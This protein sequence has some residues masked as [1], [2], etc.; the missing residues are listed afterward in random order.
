MDSEVIVKDSTTIESK[1]NLKNNNTVSSDVNSTTNTNNS[2]STD[3]SV[4]NLNNN[5]TN[6]TN[7]GVNNNPSLNNQNSS[8]TDNSAGVNSSYGQSPLSNG[9]AGPSHDDKRSGLNSPTNTG[10]NS[11]PSSSFNGPNSGSGLSDGLNKNSS[12][13]GNPSLNQKNS[14]NKTDNLDGGKSNGNPGLGAGK[15]GTGSPSNAGKTGG[16]PAI[17]G[18]PGGGFGPGGVPLSGDPRDAAKMAGRA[19]AKAALASATG[20]ATEIPVVNKL[21]DAGVGKAVDKAVDRVA[22]M[23]ENIPGSPLNKE[24]KSSPEP[25]QDTIEKLTGLNPQQQ[26]ILLVGFILFFVFVF[27][28]F[29][30]IVNLLVE[31]K[32]GILD[33]A[34]DVINNDEANQVLN[35]LNES[36]DSLNE[37]DLDA[38]YISDDIIE[39]KLVA[40]QY[41]LNDLKDMF[42]SN[43][44]CDK[45]NN[46]ANDV[47]RR[48]YLKL[49]DLYY[50][51]K[52]KYNVNLDLSL[53]ISTL[54]YNS[55]DYEN[56]FYL[57]LSD[58][59]R[60]SIV[61]QDWKPSETT[62]L[63]W[64]YDYESKPNYLVENDSSMDMQILAKNMVAKVTTEKC[65]NGDNQVVTTQDVKDYEP[66]LICDEG[67][68]LEK[69]SSKYI[70]DLD[71]Y[72]K[73]L[74]EYIEKKWYLGRRVSNPVRSSG[75]NYYSNKKPSV[76]NRRNTST[77]NNGT[78]NSNSNTQHQV[79]QTGI[80]VID[81]LNNIALG[82][83]G[84]GGSKYW[85]AYGIG[86]NEW[87]AM[88][89][90][91]LFD[92]VDGID[93][94]IKK[95]AGAGDIPR[96]SVAAGYGVW[97]EDECTDPSTVPKAGDVIVFVPTIVP[98]DKYTSRHVG[99]V[100]KVDDNY[101]YTVEGNTGTYDCTT[102]Y[103]QAK[104]YDR[105]SC[106]INGYFRPNY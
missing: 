70:L 98:F 27:G 17:S 62:S 72:K 82:E 92:Q 51:Y 91:W 93:K 2:N 24:K 101:V 31:N 48:F 79:S 90:S 88:F 25:S 10:L 43:N 11:T 21:I 65:I 60:E 41:N 32:L 67:E 86:V 18:K 46:C 4:N 50:L 39:V 45:D 69:G 78:N 71:K 80:E 89:V 13:G 84:N 52:S 37:V 85:N 96:Y 9:L 5:S 102:S 34:N 75:P 95:S 33:L 35:E 106:D 103:V 38:Y 3:G 30:V 74:P 83:V 100:Y 44:T 8:L 97:Y 28:S 22:D 59:E 61:E 105:K 76:L 7:N 53:L 57:N 99:Y 12:L 6:L 40:H 20:G 36:D 56:T 1:T 42:N 55:D 104:Q 15:S 64:D 14:L 49:Y 19:A 81:N 77:S 73:F 26:K 66:D 23:A 87:C 94:Y 68:T 29:T 63:D 58:Y 47:S 54:I 16:V